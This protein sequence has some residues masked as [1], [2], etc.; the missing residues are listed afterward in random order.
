MAIREWRRDPRI[1]VGVRLNRLR[2]SRLRGGSLSKSRRRKNGRGRDAKPIKTRGSNAIRVQQVVRPKNRRKRKNEAISSFVR[3]QHADTPTDVP[4]IRNRH[5]DERHPGT[6]TRPNR[7][8]IVCSSCVIAFSGKAVTSV[9]VVG[10][11]GP[12]HGVFGN[13]ISPDPAHVTAQYRHSRRRVLAFCFVFLSVCPASAAGRIVLNVCVLLHF[14]TGGARE[15][16]GSNSN[17]AVLTVGA[18]RTG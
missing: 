18:F 14:E 3:R 13:R 17:Y 5:D 12:V 6:R 1:R 7:N 16:V 9:R 11:E 15:T 10:A 2:Y 4:V 8:I